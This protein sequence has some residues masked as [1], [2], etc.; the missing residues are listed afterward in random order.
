MPASKFVQN[1]IKLWHSVVFPWVLSMQPHLLKRERFDKISFYHGPTLKCYRCKYQPSKRAQ[2]PSWQLFHL[3]DYIIDCTTLTDVR[4]P[5]QYREPWLH[6]SRC[7]RCEIILSWPVYPT[8]FDGRKVWETMSEPSCA[9]FGNEIQ[10]PSI[11]VID[12]ILVLGALT[13]RSAGGRWKS[14]IVQCL[15]AKL[16]LIFHTPC[17]T[18]EMIPLPL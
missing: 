12:D 16:P 6:T 1:K 17:T 5:E 2:I 8:V 14:R 4:D 3:G 18:L 15:E 9:I 13:L 7:S 11:Y 10:V